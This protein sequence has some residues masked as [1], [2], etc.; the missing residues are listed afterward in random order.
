MKSR[1]ILIRLLD[2]FIIALITTIIVAVVLPVYRNIKDEYDARTVLEESKMI[3]LSCY[4]HSLE[5]YANGETIFDSKQES[6]INESVYKDIVKFIDTDAKFYVLKV[7]GDGFSIDKMVFVF[8]DFMVTF[9]ND[10]WKVDKVK[11]IL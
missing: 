7:N 5:S 6:N 3:K 9:N 11:N 4:T 10:K 1:Q 8:D 2:F